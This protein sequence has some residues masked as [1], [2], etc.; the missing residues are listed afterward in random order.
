MDP[1]ECGIP[2]VLTA[3]DVAKLNAEPRHA[4]EVQPVATCDLEGG[5]P[6]EHHAYLQETAN[7]TGW[8]VRWEG[9]GFGGAYVLEV[10]RH[11]HLTRSVP[12][13]DWTDEEACLLWRGHPGRCDF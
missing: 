6:G 11:C 12:Y 2:V 8:W 13:E 9:N 5:H 10:L 7:R 3:D 4:H 1:D